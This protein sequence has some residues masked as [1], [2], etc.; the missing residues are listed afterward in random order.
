MFLRTTTVDG[1]SMSGI[2]VVLLEDACAS[3]AIGRSSAEQ[4]HQAAVDR[5]GYVF[6]QIETSA[7]FIARA[8]EAARHLKA[9]S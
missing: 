7:S 4:V 2:K 3:Q 8:K 6:A 9:A 5:M 1:L